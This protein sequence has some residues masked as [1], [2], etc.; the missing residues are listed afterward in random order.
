MAP[1]A[2]VHVA[3]TAAWDHAAC[4]QEASSAA[5]LVATA[6]SFTGKHRSLPLGMVK[7]VL[8]Q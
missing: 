4:M 3:A 6:V 7:N 5:L 2:P 1:V 8:I